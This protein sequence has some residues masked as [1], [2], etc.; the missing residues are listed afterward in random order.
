MQTAARAVGYSR[1]EV[2]GTKDKSMTGADNFFKAGSPAKLSGLEKAAS[3][4]RT[5]KGILAAEALAREQKTAY[6]RELRLMQTR[7]TLG[8]E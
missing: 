3:T 8:D 2:F 4:D 6:L 1:L 5:A 7:A